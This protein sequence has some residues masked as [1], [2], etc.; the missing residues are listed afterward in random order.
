MRFGDLLTS[1]PEQ[2][3]SDFKFCLGSASR[4]HWE[5]TLLEETAISGRAT[6]GGAWQ[7]REFDGGPIDIGSL[8]SS[9]AVPQT[10]P[11][12]NLVG[13]GTKFHCAR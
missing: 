2:L 9:L 13:V 5:V 10:G 6:L 7:R 11:V 1:C 4:G 3:A 8:I 12:T